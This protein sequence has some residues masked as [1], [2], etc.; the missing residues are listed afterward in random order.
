[1]TK[2]VIGNSWDVVK[3]NLARARTLSLKE[4]TC[5]M[6]CV[7]L[8]RHVV[9]FLQVLVKDNHLHTLVKTVRKVGSKLEEYQ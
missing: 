9:E 7:M 5:Q 8:W 4:V 3:F 6:L 1:M 2:S